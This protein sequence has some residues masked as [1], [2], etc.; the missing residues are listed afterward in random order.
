M[1]VEDMRAAG[2]NPVVRIARLTSYFPA[3]VLGKVC[4]VREIDEAKKFADVVA[5][6]GGGAHD[7]GGWLSI[8]CLELEPSP[9]WL[10]ARDLFVEKLAAMQAQMQDRAARWKALVE[11]LAAQHQLEPEVIESIHAELGGFA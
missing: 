6:T 3:D 1:N 2:A 7:G 5:I 10:A 11:R 8:D 4:V 9:V